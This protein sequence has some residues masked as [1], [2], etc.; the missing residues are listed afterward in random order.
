MS[1][2]VSLWML[3]CLMSLSAFTGAIA[4]LMWCVRAANKKHRLEEKLAEALEENGELRMQLDIR[5][6]TKRQERN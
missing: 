3:V 6:A 4:A 5:R 1:I 2:L